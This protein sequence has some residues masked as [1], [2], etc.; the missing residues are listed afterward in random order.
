MKE[1]IESQKQK[2]LKRNKTD[3]A[4][5]ADR[6]NTRT[7]ERHWY[8][9]GK[10][11]N[12]REPRAPS[13][14][15]CRGGHRGE[16]CNVYNTSEKRRNLF[17]ENGLCYNCGHEGHGA[18]HGRSR[19]CFKCKSGYHTS[20]YDKPSVNGPT[21]AWVKNDFRLQCPPARFAEFAWTARVTIV[22]WNQ[23]RVVRE[24]NPPF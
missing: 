3:D 1:L 22:T 11:E 20:L 8:S 13:C 21:Q 16:S 14:L 4:S 7:R 19:P 24:R 23:D 5:P 17:H 10:R 6:G 9:K 15:F 2:W 18:N 12:V